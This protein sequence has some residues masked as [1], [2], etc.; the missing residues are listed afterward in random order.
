MTAKTLTAKALTA[1]I[2][3]FSVAHR[4]SIYQHLENRACR[5]CKTRRTTLLP[6]SRKRGKGS[7]V[8]EGMQ[9][10]NNHNPKAEPKTPTMSQETTSRDYA[11]MI[12]WVQ[13]QYCI[14]PPTGRDQRCC[15]S[16]VVSTHVLCNYLRSAFLESNYERERSP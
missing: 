16:S 13:L 14:G 1:K 2:D 7:Q 10:A 9:T 4:P 5:N 12:H 3:R 11:N 6:L 8:R 15:V